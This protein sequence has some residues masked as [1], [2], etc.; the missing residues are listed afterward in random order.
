[1]F[2]KKNTIFDKAYLPFAGFRLYLTK[3]AWRYLEKSR[4]TQCLKR[5]GKRQGF[6][7]YG[8]FQIFLKEILPG[9]SI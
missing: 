1:M 4:K 7:F 5:L 6:H 8:I 2:G 3:F 9:Q